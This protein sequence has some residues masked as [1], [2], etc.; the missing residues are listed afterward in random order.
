MP[1]GAAATVAATEMIFRREH[2]AFAL[3][4]E[5]VFPRRKRR[6]WSVARGEFVPGDVGVVR[7]SLQAGR[8]KAARLRKIRQQ[9]QET[10]IQQ[11]RT[12]APARTLVRNPAFEPALIRSGTHRAVPSASANA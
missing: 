5:L 2:D 3:H 4:V 12:F 9:P 1:A 7:Q 10:R 11:D 6:S 8:A